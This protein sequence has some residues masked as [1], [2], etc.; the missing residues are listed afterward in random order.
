MCLHGAILG[1]HWPRKREELNTYSDLATGGL[2]TAMDGHVR[3]AARSRNRNWITERCRL[4][5]LFGA[6]APS[7][8]GNALHPYS[9][10]AH[11]HWG[12]Y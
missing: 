6:R 1:S 8:I 4:F 10:R 2:L 11:V 9:S 3:G 7:C 12:A 5:G